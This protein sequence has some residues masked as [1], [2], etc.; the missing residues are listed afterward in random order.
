[1]VRLER[2]MGGGERRRWVVR[3]GNWVE[4]VRRYGGKWERVGVKGHKCGW[5]K[6]EN[7]CYVG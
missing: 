6:T 4:G 5:S 2:K 3:D 7:V 1:M